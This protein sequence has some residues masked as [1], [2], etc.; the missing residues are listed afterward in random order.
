M[1]TIPLT[2]GKYAIVDDD[3]YAALVCFNWQAFDNRYQWYARRNYPVGPYKQKTISMHK[4]LLNP[5]KGVYVDHRDGNG[6]NNMRSNLR[7]ATRGQN[8]QNCRKLKPCSSKYKGVFWRANRKRFVA[9]IYYNDKT[10]RL[11]SFRT[12]EEAAVMYDVA[13]QIC[14]GEFACLNGV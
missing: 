3:D 14:F 6:L 1:K 4:M 2:Q 12:E 9:Q 13:A 10:Y 8:K 11:G 7:L 5:P